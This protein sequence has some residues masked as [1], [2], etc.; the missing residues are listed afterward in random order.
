MARLPSLYQIKMSGE[1]MTNKKELTVN[2]KALCE[3]IYTLGGQNNWN[4]L[5]EYSF[6]YQPVMEIFKRYCHEVNDEEA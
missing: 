5:S 3:M 4:I 2:E 1:T 6:D